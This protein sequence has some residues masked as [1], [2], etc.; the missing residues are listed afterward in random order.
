MPEN[1]ETKEKKYNEKSSKK[2]EKT[3]KKML[4]N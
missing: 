3:S 1:R 2:V 4:E